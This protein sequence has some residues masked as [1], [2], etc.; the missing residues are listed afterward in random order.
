MKKLTKLLSL[1]LVFALAMGIVACSS[2]G[3]VEKALKELGFA[4]IEND[5]QAEQYQDVESISEIHVLEK[6]TILGK[7][8]VIV[9]EFKSTDKMVEYFNESDTLKGLVSDLS[10]NEDVKAMHAKLEELGLACDNC[11]IVPS[12][13]NMVDVMTKISEL[14]K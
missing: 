4:V 7:D 10:K 13:L 9:L 11:L 8:Y 2:Y 14:N 12:L 1:L 3:K 5:K 6:S